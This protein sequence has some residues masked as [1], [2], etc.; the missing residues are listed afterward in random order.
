M[1]APWLFL[2]A[3][4]AFFGYGRSGMG[5]VGRLFCCFAQDGFYG[6]SWAFCFWKALVPQTNLARASTPFFVPSI[7]A[8]L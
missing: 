5:V 4:V 1:R 2:I 3:M 7:V 6:V 8:S